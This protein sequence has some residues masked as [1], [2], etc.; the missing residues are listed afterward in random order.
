VALTGREPFGVSESVLASFVRI[1][2]HHR[3]YAE[4]TP[5]T[6]ALDFCAVV[7]GAPSTVVV[8]A[9]ADH[10]TLFRSLVLDAGARGN[11]IPDAALAAFAL[12]HGATWVTAD[13]GF[14]RFIGLRSVSPL[15]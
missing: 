5:P 7:L 15:S 13:R 11:A 9:G 4:P 2:T 14:A 12:E 10:W 3:V 1:V 6:V 8:R